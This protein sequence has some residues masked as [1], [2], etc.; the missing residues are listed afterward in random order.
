MAGIGFRLNRFIETGTISGN[1]LAFAYSAIIA[2]G[3]WIITSLALSTL[4]NYGFF[5]VIAQVI[6]N[7]FTNMTDREIIYNIQNIYSKIVNE[8]FSVSIVYSF[9]FSTV[10][11]G[12][13]IMVL[14]RNIS[15]KIY[16]DNYEDIFSDTVGFIMISQIISLIVAMIF[17][18]IYDQ[19]PLWVKIFVT[20]LFIS[21][22]TLWVVSVAA[23]ATDSYVKY[24]LAFV[25]TGFSSVI[26]S[27][28]FGL[29]FGP[30]GSVA[31]YALGVNVGISYMLF[32]VGEYFGFRLKISF[33]W[34]KS[35]VVYWQNLV[36]GTFYYLSIW[37]DD[38]VTW[39]SP[40]LG[41][42]Y[43]RYGLYGFRL[44][45]DYDSPMFLA[46][47]T[48][49]PTMAMFVLVLETYFY[50]KYKLFYQNITSGGTYSDIIISKNEMIQEMK[51]NISLV[52]KF[53]IIIT[54]IIYFINDIN[55]IVSQNAGLSDII[56]R[57]GIVGAM[58]NGFYLMITLL[59]LYFD[60]RKEVMLLNILTFSINIG[61][62]YGL[63]SVFDNKLLGFSYTIA[64][65]ISTFI[66]Y[67]I[68]IKK[69]ENIEKIE[70]NR[71]KMYTKEGFYI[72]YDD[73]EKY[74][75]EKK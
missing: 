23:V 56:R 58:M 50:K 48:T 53:Q 31:G 73:I 15:D 28:F 12:G 13:I 42:S 20:W 49:I 30:V 63:F 67:K 19:N 59:L 29:K 69:L 51:S 35:I 34:A 62:S 44:A 43:T 38:I 45:Y 2:A 61:L 25:I 72:N 16:S 36:I 57:I 66:G 4:L 52:V 47:L 9:V 55:I 46:Y 17:F 26:F 71:Q 65:T 14:S 11:T 6:L 7:V 75:K 22:S 10:I 37:I 3:P 60:F 21:L 64:F 39:A 70:F 74:V 32:M 40:Q 1:V 41:E 8:Y 27:I 68:L 33:A 54:A 24:L 18:G 5:K